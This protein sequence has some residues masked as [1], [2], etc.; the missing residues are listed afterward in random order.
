MELPFQFEQQLDRY[1][2]EIGR[3]NTEPTRAHLFLELIRQTFGSLSAGYAELL[4]PELES[5]VSIKQATLAVQGRIDALLSN[6]VIEFKR[7]LDANTLADARDKLKKYIAALYS[8]NKRD[9]LA[10]ASDG[11]NFIVYL[12][13]APASPG[14][15]P[16]QVSLNQVDALDITTTGAREVYL[17]LD[18]YLLAERLITPYTGYFV[19]QFGNRY[20][21]TYIL[22]YLQSLWEQNKSNY[23]GL[24]REWADYLSIVYGTR[25]ESEQLFLRH[26]YLATLAKLIAYQIFSVGKSPSPSL[27][28]DIL[29]GS[30]FKEW[31]IINF[32]E[33]DFFSWLGRHEQGINIVRE[34]VQRLSRFNMARMDEDVLKGIYQ[35]L[36]DPEERHDL[37]EYYT[38]EWIAQRMVRCLLKPDPS[39]S[40]LDPGCGSGTFLATA[41]RYKLH[42]MLLRGDEL[43]RH[44]LHTV[45]GIDIHPLA[46]TIAKTNYLLALRPLLKARFGFL[47][48]PIYMADSLQPQAQQRDINGVNVYEKIID[49]ETSLYVPAAGD[50]AAIDE[51]VEA[52]RRY[53][54]DLAHE[55]E[56]KPSILTYLRAMPR[57]SRL[58]D[59][60]QLT[61]GHISVLQNT[62]QALAKLINDPQHGDTIWA[63]VLKNFY[64]PAFL[65]HTFDVVVGNP[66]WLSY[67]Y[68]DNPDYQAVLKRLITEHYTLATKAELMTHME[69]ATLFFLASA[70]NY[71]K[72]DGDI[73]FVMPRAIL[74]ADQHDIFRKGKYKHLQLGFWRIDDLYEVGPIFK[75]KG[76]TVPPCLLFA[77]KRAETPNSIPGYKLK[78]RLPGRNLSLEDVDTNLSISPVEFSLVTHGQRSYITSEAPSI[79]IQEGRSYYYSEFRNG[80]SIQPR[81]FWFIDIP[82]HPELGLNSAKPFVRSSLRA[83]ERAKSEYQGVKLEGNVEA[84][85]LYA[86]LTSSE[87]LPFAHFPF[88]PVILPLRCES[89]VYIL[90]D[91]EW[92]QREGFPGLAS[93]LKEAEQLWRQRR[94][95][96]AAQADVYGWLDYRHKLTSQSPETPFKV[97]YIAS[98]TH[99]AACVVDCSH[100]LEITVD[101]VTI[102]LQHFVAETKTYYCETCDRNEAMYL[103]SILNSEIIDKLVKP[104][105]SRG[106]FGERDFHKKPLEFPVPKYDPMMAE[107]QRLAELGQY[108][109]DRAQALVNQGSLPKSLPRA[110]QYIRQTLNKELAEI[111]HLTARVLQ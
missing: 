48:I 85:Y 75:E 95:V 94:G 68:V 111:D 1:K 42:N 108:C 36:V 21:R 56:S 109:S 110:R 63:F 25:V 3:A 64:K 12:P 50:P 44:I 93:W 72:E 74:T 78:G 5:S 84:Q 38:P 27:I 61:E 92:A 14:L 88:L 102:P 100:G 106:L 6:L 60:H 28:R 52:A 59:N 58:I 53:A 73:G 7:Q 32:I 35:N 96:K 99:L 8:Q 54:A 82:V 49:E 98:G 87:V 46:V 11:V 62:G 65:L 33:E 34:L 104:L 55:P 71:L 80:A 107:H 70:E 101:G 69:L 90:C 47:A 51:M 41:I 20:F 57:I 23:Q 9:Y 76:G 81:Q 37:G 91:R 26:T 97:L 19:D 29:N 31:G 17:W 77:R 22:P 24:Y 18:R 4:L 2:T 45:I 89:G 13:S 40:V 43:L 30:A 83:I 105:Q 67:R 66:P 86:T 39:K 79:T 103:L 16:D 15:S 10:L